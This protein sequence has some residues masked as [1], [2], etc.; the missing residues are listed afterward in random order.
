M[1]FKEEGFSTILL[2]CR[3]ELGR[4]QIQ[5]NTLPNSIKIVTSICHT[6]ILSNVNVWLYNCYI[7]Q[8]NI[9]A[10]MYK[11]SMVSVHRH[12]RTACTIYTTYSCDVLPKKQFYYIQ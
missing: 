6:Y 12:Y 2:I 3:K 5:N 10:H 7:I 11:T 1:L 4:T 9:Q 8:V